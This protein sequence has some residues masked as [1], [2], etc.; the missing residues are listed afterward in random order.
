VLGAENIMVNKRHNPCLH[1]VY[2]P[3]EK[4]DNKNKQV[5]TGG[6]A[7]MAEYLLCMCEAPSSN[8]KST[9]KKQKATQ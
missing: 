9:N 5:G 6:V 2:N 1:G 4:T 3:E 8:P 7:Q